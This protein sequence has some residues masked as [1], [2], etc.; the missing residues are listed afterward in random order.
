[1]LGVLGK[2]N[3]GKTTFFNAA[4]SLSAQV[5]NFPFT[6]VSPNMGIANVRVTCVCREM[7]VTDT[8]SNSS[9]IDGNRLIP[10]RLVD[11]AGLVPGASRG[12]GLGNKFLDDVRQADALIHVV[13]AS[14]SSD[15]EGRSCPPGSHD[16]VSD[17]E[18]V[19]KEFDTWM[20]GI[21]QKD[22]SYIARSAES[23]ARKLTVALSE[24]LSGLKIGESE[25]NASISALDLSK[26][27]PNTWSKDDLVRFCREL[28]EN[29]K[30]SLVVANKIDIGSSSDN[31]IKLKGS[32]REVVPCAAEAEVML[33]RASEKGLIKYL[34]GDGDF[35]VS[36]K[37]TG[38]QEKALALVKDKILNKFGST[39]VQEA[40][41]SAYFKLLKNI[42][43]YPVED[44]KN[45]TDKKGRVLPDAFLVPLGSTVRDL[46]Y[47]IHTDLGES[48]LY[49]IDARKGTRLGVDAVLNDRDIVK[50]VSSAKRT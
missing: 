3:V 8:P 9:C 37:M 50:I 16:P 43:V 36:S 12:R 42:V 1:M 14:G 34:P 44:E 31:L 20:Y 10:I 13:D 19:E 32:G 46:A 23:G 21:L 4:T 26:D 48:I 28:R 29:S 5:A 24:K 38:D 11:V 35:E 27:K 6:T 47:R 15:E 39:G 30:P 40:I 33:R 25:I 2:P 41:N 49:A 18:F 22:W 7:N 17:L 45:L